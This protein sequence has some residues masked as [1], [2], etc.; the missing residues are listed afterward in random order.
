MIGLSDFR[1]NV[2]KRIFA[3]RNNTSPKLLE[4]WPFY[5]IGFIMFIRHTK[6]AN[7]KSPKK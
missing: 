7:S 6:L 4:I 3:H 1:P 2:Q 5:L